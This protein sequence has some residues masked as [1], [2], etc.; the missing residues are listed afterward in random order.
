MINKFLNLEEDSLSAY[1]KDVRKYGETITIEKEVELAKKIKEGDRKSLD[2]LV[3]AN[4][5][6]VIKIAK[7][8]QNQGVPVADLINEGN[9]GL[10]VAASRFDHT[11][12][13]RFISYAIW[14]IK[15]SILQCLNEHSRTV[16]LPGNVINKLSKIKKEIEQ[17]EKDNNRSPL[18]DEVHQIEVPNCTSLNTAINED[19]DELLNII[20]DNMFKRPDVLQ[21]EEDELKNLE[22]KRAMQN[23]SKREIEI[24]NC[25][26]GIGG[27]PMTLEMIGEEL[28]LTKERVRQIKESAIRKI[29]NNLGG[30]FEI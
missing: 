17:F 26:F 4:L 8:Y 22:M 24:I 30:I 28:E 15:Q 25:Y 9:Y 21:E 23:L 27:E 18:E 19:G 2:E 6:F 20:E 14:W 16:R 5:R 12:G 7:E 3:N 13:F 11:K 10:T 29:R 1:M